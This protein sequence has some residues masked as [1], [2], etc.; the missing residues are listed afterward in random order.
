M[1]TSTAQDFI[2]QA[3][4]MINVGALGETIP[5]AQL[6]AAFDV[7]NNMLDSWS[8]RSLLT[9]ALIQEDFV[10]TANKGVYTIGS[11]YGT[12]PVI[13]ADFNT[14]RPIEIVSAFI[15]D[16]NDVQ[17]PVQVVPR[18]TYDSYTDKLITGE[19]TRPQALYFDPG[20][21]QQT[22]QWG[23]VNLYPYPDSADTYTLYIDSEKAFTEFASLSAV[24]TFPPVYRRAI[25]SNLA[26]ELAPLY[27]K[28]LHPEVLEIAHESMRIVENINS[29]NKRIL[30]G[31][32]FTGKARS[33]NI[34]S[35][36]SEL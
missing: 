18:E 3:L 25:I 6:N 13:T 27:G 2:T 14:A 29:R 11:S 4:A 26:L 33:F 34:F 24:V 1:A 30:A 9:T 7:L 22:A 16:S 8:G 28:T 36:M 15:Q 31:M 19:V 12:M 10:L 5:T 20:V 32:D 23:T 17:Y 21:T 35:G